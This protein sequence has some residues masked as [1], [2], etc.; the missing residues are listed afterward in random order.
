[1]PR[2]QIRGTQT[3]DGSITSADLADGAVTTSKLQD[4][5]VTEQKLTSNVAARLLSTASPVGRVHLV[6]AVPPDT[7]ITIPGG[8]TYASLADFLDRLVVT[9]NGQMMYSGTA[10]PATPDDP[11]DVYPGSSD[12]K[13]RFSFALERGSRIQVVHL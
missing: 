9:L 7:D 11:T 8:I 4:L 12:S 6:G 1:M 2:T 3:C 5:G 10:P 13:V